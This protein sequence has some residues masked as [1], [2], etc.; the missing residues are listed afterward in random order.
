MSTFVSA[1]RQWRRALELVA[2]AVALS[3]GAMADVVPT[4]GMVIDADTTFVPGTYAL[5]QGVSIGA[6]GVTLD[7]NGATLLGSDFDHYGVTCTGHD[8]VTIKNGA[9]HGYY[10]GMRIEN[11]TGATV[12]G[13]DLSGNW[14][15]PASL[16]TPPPFLNIN[17]G[18][19]LGDRTNLGGGL[20]LNGLS[21]AT[22]ADNVLT[23]QENGIDAYTVTDSTIS[24]N[25]ASDNTGWGIHLYACTDNVII[26]N[27]ADH[28]IRPYLY[29]SAGFLV[30]YGSSRNQFLNNS[31]K[32]GGDGFFIGNEWGCPSNDNLIQGNDGSY[33]G[34]NAFEATFSSGNQFIDNTAS[35]SNYGFWLGYSHDGNVIRG[36]RILA[37]NTNGIEIE[38]GQNNVIE[39]NLFTGNGG[40]AIVLR[41]D[42][43]VHFPVPSFPCLNMPN[44]AYSRGYTIKDNII[45][46]NFSGAMQLTNTTD[47]A[48]Y[49]NLIA[50][51]IGGT[52]VASNGANNTWSITPTP[53]TN[54]IG[55]AMLGGNYWS[56]YTGADTTGDGLG[57]T[58]LPYT[59]D[60]QIAAP[61]DP[62]PL[63]GDVDLPGFGNP[64][65]LCDRAWVDLGVNTHSDGSTFG[66]AN[67]AHFA[68][69]GTELYLLEGNN[70]TAFDWFD[71]VTGRYERRASLPEGVWDGGELEAGDGVYYAGPGLQF[72]TSTG[73]GK[74]SR[75]YAYEP[76]SDS[77]SSAAGCQVGGFYYAHEALAYDPVG[78][79]LYATVLFRQNVFVYGMF[80]F[81]A[82][83][84]FMLFK[85]RWG[86][87]HRAVGE[88]PKAADTLGVNVI[89]TRYMA[90]ILGGMMA[91]FAGAY[92]TLGSVGKFDQVMTAGRGFIALAAMI[93]G[94]YM[95]VGAMIAG[96]LFGFSDS[97]AA[98]LAVLRVKIPS[99]FLL[100][101]PYLITM[102][103]LAGVV[104]RAQIPAAGGK[105]YDKE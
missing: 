103:V 62:H 42:G 22:I 90:V 32:Y 97:L 35:G 2:V 73:D 89:R 67:G 1:G 45:H 68:T 13:N 63:V 26:G 47:S 39:G 4:D 33:A 28:C 59:N 53:G 52:T 15:D 57:D 6:S 87:R 96:L 49:N 64:E 19:N 69:D 41:T 84:T 88:H 65:T 70:G 44:Q 55:G 85:T 40:R 16:Q 58:E 74:G 98:S 30:V 104:G 34:A 102:L 61:G 29:D 79:H 11:G 101:T 51:N 23:G 71:P 76:A 60:G 27:T 56:N 14:L 48:I 92:F 78:Q 66:T 75:L 77:W 100:M 83:L 17:V 94:N 3:A 72:Y 86:L 12:L 21:G 37:N 9:A 24:G 43:Q 91:G 10:Y 38:H 50:N 93:F 99:E 80:F 81:V 25:E 20:F 31:F 7:M 36:N 8:N 105:P 46:S 18:P 95:P 54:I 82:L 5:P